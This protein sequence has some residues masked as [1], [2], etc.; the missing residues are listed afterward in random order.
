MAALPVTLEKFPTGGKCASP[1]GIR[2]RV[3][4]GCLDAM[5]CTQQKTLAKRMLDQGLR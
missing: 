4:I 2:V 3:A 5:R 1:S